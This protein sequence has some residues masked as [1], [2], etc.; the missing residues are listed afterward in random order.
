MTLISRSGSIAL[1]LYALCVGAALGV[2]WDIFRVIRI[3]AYGRRK[4]PSKMF[5]R[6]PSNEREVKEIL[7]VGAS[8]KLSPISFLCVF[9]SDLAFCIFAAICM[10]LLIF[11]SNNGEFRG[12][13]LW[14]AFIGFAV[15]YFTVGKLTV[16][17][18]EAIIKVIKKAIAIVFSLTLKPIL[19]LA[20]RL[21]GAITSALT[22]H[23]RRKATERY[24]EYAMKNAD[25][26]FGI[27]LSLTSGKA[28][29][30]RK[31][32]RYERLGQ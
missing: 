30:I 26:A 6:L 32:S 16:I 3:A 28:V 24:I 12:F 29:S 11:R 1:L 10:I 27:S 13:A 14:G 31:K 23:K 2:L 21:F 15:Y 18:S 7:R 25:N 4:R 19:K 22:L 17:F 8:D 9:L 5:V 20:L